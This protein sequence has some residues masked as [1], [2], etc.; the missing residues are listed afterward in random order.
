MFTTQPQHGS[1]IKPSTGWWVKLSVRV[2][3]LVA[4]MDGTLFILAGRWD[5]SGAWLLTILYVVFLLVIIVWAARNAPELLE[6]RSRVASNVKLWD[7]VLLAL[8]T[9]ALVGL[10]VVAALDA[11]RF[12]W[13]EMPVVI[14]VLGVLGIVPCGAWLLWVTRTNAYLSRFARIQDDRGQQVVSTGP[15][16]FVRHPMYASIIPFIV[17]VALILGSWWALLPGVV[18]AVLFVIRTALED[19]MLQAELPGYQEYARRVRYRIVPGVW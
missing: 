8:Y 3:A 7:K 17:C 18:I 16:R 19:R 14:Q 2:L 11:G 10:L 13:T 1:S 15:Y 12:R 5:W 4:I 6:E 9:T